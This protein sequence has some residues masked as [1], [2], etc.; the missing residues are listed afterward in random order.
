MGSYEL[1][2]NGSWT[3]QQRHLQPQVWLP[4]NVGL[5]VM[6]VISVCVLHESFANMTYET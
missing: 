3:E 2:K 1:N 6:L 4:V 5:V